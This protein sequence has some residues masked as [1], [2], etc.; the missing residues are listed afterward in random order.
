MW[1]N[2]ALSQKFKKMKATGE[3]EEE[4]DFHDGKKYFSTERPKPPKE[5]PPQP[6]QVI[7]NEGRK[8]HGFERKFLKDIRAMMNEHKAINIE[9][10]AAPLPISG[11]Y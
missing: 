6:A 10:Y 2:N 1:R 3:G 8:A 11:G 9:W 7:E 4:F 5:A